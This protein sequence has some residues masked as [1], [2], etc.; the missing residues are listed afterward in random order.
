MPVVPVKDAPKYIPRTAPA[1]RD[2]R[3]YSKPR[4]SSCGD[5]IPGNGY[6]SAFL[7]DGGRVSDKEF[8]EHLTAN[9]RRE[10]KARIAQPLPKVPSCV[11]RQFGEYL[12]RLR[13]GDRC[14]NRAENLGQS[15][16]KQKHYLHRKA[17]KAYDR[18]YER[19]EEELSTTPEHLAWLDRNPN[20]PWQNAGPDGPGLANISYCP[21]GMP[22][23]ID[24]RSP[25]NQTRTLHNKKDR[26]QVEMLR[27]ILEG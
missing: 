11:K 2:I 17:E 23:L 9:E 24:Y 14:Y 21:E 15:H 3:F 26:I 10:Y 1:I 22:R 4:V 5:T 25:N 8:K 12:E 18:A 13:E 19:L 27:S 7:E 6:D 20:F 16:R